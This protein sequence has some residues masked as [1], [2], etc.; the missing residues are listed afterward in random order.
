MVSER[1]LSRADS[2]TSGVSRISVGSDV[3]S[4]S[5]SSRSAGLKR[6]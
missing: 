3:Q 2:E 6:S 4:S 1:N 5:I